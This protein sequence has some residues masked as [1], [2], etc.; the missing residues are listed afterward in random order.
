MEDERPRK[1]QGVSRAFRWKE[2]MKKTQSNIE[3]LK[4][5]PKAYD[6]LVARVGEFSPVEISL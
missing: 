2:I 5:N 6:K 3:Y 1:I 4:E